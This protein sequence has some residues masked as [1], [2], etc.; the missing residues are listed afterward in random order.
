MSG[1]LCPSLIK[2]I[3][4][5]I[6]FYN[7]QKSC[8]LFVIPMFLWVGCFGFVFAVKHRGILSLS[9]DVIQNFRIVGY[10]FMKFKNQDYLKGLAWYCCF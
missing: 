5:R 7:T 6:F 1:N 10:P 9:P 4:A 8:K 2:D 3:K